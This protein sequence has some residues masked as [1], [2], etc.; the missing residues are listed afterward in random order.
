MPSNETNDVQGA[1][2]RNGVFRISPDETS[3]QDWSGKNGFFSAVS[4]QPLI[5]SILEYHKK[6]HFHGVSAFSIPLFGETVISGYDYINLLNDSPQVL[7]KNL[8]HPF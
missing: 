7:Q 1:L 8:P 5:M 6:I 4:S 3:I 2:Q